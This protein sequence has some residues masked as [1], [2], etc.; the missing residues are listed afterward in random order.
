MEAKAKLIVQWTKGYEGMFWTQNRFE[1][2]LPQPSRPLQN[3]LSSTFWATLRPLYYINW[4]VAVQT[5]NV[6]AQS[7]WN[8]YLRHVS[9]EFAGKYWP[10][11]KRVIYYFLL[12]SSFILCR[13][14]L[15][16]IKVHRFMGLGSLE[17]DS[18]NLVQCENAL[19]NLLKD[20][21]GNTGSKRHYKIKIK[22]NMKEILMIYLIINSWQDSI[23]KIC[24]KW[25]NNA[26]THECAQQLYVLI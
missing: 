10:I 25:P 19:K 23:S 16:H 17:S 22:V 1:A 8:P 13:F 3:F 18:W 15:T 6:A 26:I 11:E 4:L 24:Y 9:W 5:F 21:N 7:Y 2:S 20:T 14:N 12:E